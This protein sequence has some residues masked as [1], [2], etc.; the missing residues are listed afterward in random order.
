MR[1]LMICLDTKLTTIIMTQLGMAPNPQRR[2]PRGTRRPAFA[3]QPSMGWLELLSSLTSRYRDSEFE[4][5]AV[6]SL[7]SV[8]VMFRGTMCSGVLSCG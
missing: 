4:G 7:T 1:L 3:S 2:Y 5:M 6:M 8:V